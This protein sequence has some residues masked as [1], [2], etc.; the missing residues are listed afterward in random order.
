MDIWGVF[1]LRFCNLTENFKNGFVERFRM[2]KG[3]IENGFIVEGKYYNEF[4][5]AQRILSFGSACT[6]L[7]PQD[8]REKIIQK[9]KSMRNNYNG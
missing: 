4:L 6:V 8:F 3:Y 7:E 1:S 2:D 9:L 5:A